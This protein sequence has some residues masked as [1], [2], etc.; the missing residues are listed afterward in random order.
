ML[1]VGSLIN[2]FSQRWPELRRSL[3]DRLPEQGAGRQELFDPSRGI[4]RYGQDMGSV[5]QLPP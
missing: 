2:T 3:A 4:D 1:A 5:I